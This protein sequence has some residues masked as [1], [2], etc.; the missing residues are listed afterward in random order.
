MLW[1][2]TAARAT[3]SWSSDNRIYFVSDRG[4]SPQIYRM[5]ATGGAPER[6]TFTGTYNISPALSADGRWLA[7]I[8]RVNGVFKLHVMELPTGNVTALTETGGI[9]RERVFLA[10][11]DIAALPAA[12]DPVAAAVAGAAAIDGG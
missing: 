8:S 4:G 10:T 1:P 5:P 11:T 9:S 2:A 7:Y 3:P 12:A 6:V